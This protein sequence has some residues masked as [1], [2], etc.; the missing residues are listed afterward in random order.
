MKRHCIHD[1]RIID[2]LG[3]DFASADVFISGDTI[4]DIRIPSGPQPA[5]WQAIPGQKRTLMPGLIDGHV[6]LLFDASPQA[7][8]AMLNRSRDQLIA[9]A[10]GRAGITLQAGVTSIRELSGTAKGMFSLRDVLKPETAAPRIYDCFTPLTSQGGFGREVCFELTRDNAAAI[11]RDVAE[12]ADMIK[13]LGDR[14]DS[15][16]PDGL[17]P[18]FDD[19]TFELICRTCRDLGKPLDVHAKCRAV[20]KQCLRHGVNSIEHGVRAESDDLKEMAAQGVHLNAT[21]WGLRCRSDHQPDFDE[22]MRVMSF[23]PRARDAGVRLTLGSDSGAV[24]TP[25]GGALSEIEYMVQAGLAPM[26]AI[27]GATSLN[28]ERIADPTIGAVAVGRKADL[29]MIAEDP[30]KSISALRKSLVWVM[31]DGEIVHHARADK[32]D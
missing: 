13:V 15:T 12:K 14:Y 23:Y 7:P 24:F 10:L 32:L 2:G 29:L 18:Q 11:I 27:T 28:A 21:F 16:A 25:H 31:K 17:A 1:V 8:L 9:D 26:Q 19:A 30:L 6:H 5:D 20:I 4:R 3:N 22:F